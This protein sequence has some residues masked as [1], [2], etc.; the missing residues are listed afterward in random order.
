MM[1]QLLL[2][3]LLLLVEAVAERAIAMAVSLS[4]SLCHTHRQVSTKATYERAMGKWVSFVW[5]RAGGTHGGTHI[6][7]Y[8]KSDTSGPSL[9]AT[10]YFAFRF[11]FR[12]LCVP[13][14]VP[15]Q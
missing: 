10:G 7:S 3:L 11:V 2:L 9:L 1:R 5:A 13:M 8:P 4:L 6:R 15:M 14:R 12:D